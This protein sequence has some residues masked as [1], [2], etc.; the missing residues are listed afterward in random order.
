M[1]DEAASVD[2][3]SGALSVQPLHLGPQNGNHVSELVL[4]G[5]EAPGK[6]RKTELEELVVVR[7]VKHRGLHIADKVLEEGADHDVDDLT[8]FQVDVFAQGCAQ[9]EALEFLTAGNILF[10][11]LLVQLVQRGVGELFLIDCGTE[12]ERNVV[13]QETIKQKG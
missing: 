12:V 11:R 8:D 5:Y 2:L 13:H 9:V 4:V 6:E 7:P 10:G 1:V 3:E